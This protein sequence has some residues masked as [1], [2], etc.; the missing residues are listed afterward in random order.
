MKSKWVIIKVAAAIILVLV[1][2][3]LAVNLTAR[4]TDIPHTRYTVG[5]IVY[6][7]EQP[8]D[9]ETALEVLSR[10]L[11][12]FTGDDR[13]YVTNLD[14]TA[15]SHMGRMEEWIISGEAAGAGPGGIG[16][17]EDLR[18]MLKE[19]AGCDVGRIWEA[20]YCLAEPNHQNSS[21]YHLLLSTSDG[22][23]WFAFVDRSDSNE[24]GAAAAL[25]RLRPGSPCRMG[26]SPSSSCPS[27]R[28][29][30]RSSCRCPA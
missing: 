13:L 10:T 28:S 1:G 17:A 19:Y 22:R 3:V 30:G 24:R 25:L 7:Y 12:M 27:S 8:Q 9:E 2:M 18:G 14:T 4:N 20:R 5:R 11:L 26:T 6:L 21:P 16:G 29:T 15:W 23:V